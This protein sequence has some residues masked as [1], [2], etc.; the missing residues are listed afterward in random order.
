MIPDDAIRLTLP[1]DEDLVSVVV[2]ALGALARATGMST[3]EVDRI[4]EQAAEAFLSV[5][6]R[7]TGDLVEATAWARRTSS[8][9]EWLLDIERS[10]A[11]ET[12]QSG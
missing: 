8:G 11:T 5:L 3:G 6:A 9:N 4:R 12:R 2:A 7:G 1:P 10:G